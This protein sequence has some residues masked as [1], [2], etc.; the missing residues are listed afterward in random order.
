M[1]C[2][3]FNIHFQ[4]KIR[5]IFAVLCL[6]KSVIF[7]K[8]PLLD[9]IKLVFQERK[10]MPA[11]PLPCPASSW[12]GCDLL[13]SPCKDSAHWCP[14][15]RPIS[16]TLP[17]VSCSGSHPPS[18]LLPLTHISFSAAFTFLSILKRGL[19]LRL[20]E[21]KWDRVCAWELKERIWVWPVWVPKQVS[22]IQ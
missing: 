2:F 21:G 16:V 8:Y 7:L 1:D 17:P 14:S 22:K 13:E 19:S 20:L 15:W 3:S 4:A 12:A 11:H 10:V 6:Y 5:K 18:A 9:Q